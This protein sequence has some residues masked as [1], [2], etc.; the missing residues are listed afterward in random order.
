MGTAALAVGLKEGVPTAF[1]PDVP[2]LWNV[3]PTSES[4]GCGYAVNGPFK[5]DPGRTHVSLDDDETLRAAGGLGD[6]LGKG[7]IELHDALVCPTDEVRGLLDHADG[8]SF[9]TSLWKV[10]ACGLDNQQPLQREFLLQLHGDGRGIS[11]WMAARS[12]VPSGLPE[13]FAQVLPPLTSGT[14][15]EV[16]NGGLDNETFCHALDEIDD[17]DLVALVEGRCIVSGKTRGL[18]RPLCQDGSGIHTVPAPTKRPVAG[19]GRS[20]GPLLDAGSLA[21]VATHRPRRGLGLNREQSSRHN[22]APH[23]QG[24]GSGW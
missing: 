8:R 5:L 4:W 15:I 24:S 14:R 3:T 18:L 21:C 22:L 16:A 11:A 6:A 17:E 12:A 9:L 20:V 1:R 2:F 7:L 23:T 13:P 19:T 10:L